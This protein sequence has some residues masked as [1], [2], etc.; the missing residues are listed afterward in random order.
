VK[1]GHLSTAA[2]VFAAQLIAL[3]LEDQ[4][5]IHRLLRALNAF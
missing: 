1:S 5:F 3:A 4:N 2:S